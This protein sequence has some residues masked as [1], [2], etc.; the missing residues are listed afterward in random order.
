MA[1]GVGPKPGYY[2]TEFWVTILCQLVGLAAF[3]SPAFITVEQADVIVRAITQLGGIIAMVAS[4]F[5]YS[6]SR[7][8]AK[9]NL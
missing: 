8:A 2:T 7:G 1:N 5:G 3:V 6:L 4:A 9:K